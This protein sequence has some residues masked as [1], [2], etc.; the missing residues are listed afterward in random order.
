[1]TPYARSCHH[2]TVYTVHCNKPL[3]MLPAL[4][5]ASLHRPVV[6]D[7]EQLVLRRVQG[8]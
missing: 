6:V 4:R 3:H 2:V 7:E 8:N 1:M 5:L